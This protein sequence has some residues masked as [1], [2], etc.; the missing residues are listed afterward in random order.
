MIKSDESYRSQPIPKG[1]LEAMGPFVEQGFKS[2]NLISTGGLRPSSEGHK[3]RLSGGKMR[4][5][6]GPFTESKEIIGGYA[7]MQF[8]TKEEA[9]ENAK[10]FMELHRVHWPEFECECEIRPMD[11]N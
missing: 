3:I 7:I 9:L 6:D 1:L 10:Q 11:D 4:V 5:S 8:K 2:G